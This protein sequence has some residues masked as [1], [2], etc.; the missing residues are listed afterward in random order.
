MLCG[1]REGIVRGTPSP[2]VVAWLGG[3]GVEGWGG[4]AGA[5]ALAV[6]GGTCIHATHL[7]TNS[8]IL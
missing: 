1:R 6:E 7:L 5:G 4:G 3:W 8:R 2:E